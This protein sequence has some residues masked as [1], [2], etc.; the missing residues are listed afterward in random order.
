MLAR[1]SRGFVRRVARL[2]PVVLA[3]GLAAALPVIVSTIRAVKAGWLPLGDDAMIVVRALDV[4]STHSPLVGAHSASSS[5]I[6]APVASP[7][8]MLFWLLALPARLGHVAP[9]I[10]MGAV[11]TAAVVGMVALARRRGGVVLMLVVAGALALMCRSL[12]AQIYHDVWNPSAAVLPFAL[13]VFLAWSVA[14]GEHALLPLIVVVGSFAAQAQLAYALPV[15]ALFAVALAFLVGSRVPVPRRT[16][17]GA[18]LALLVCWSLPLAEEVVHR[19]GNLVRIGQVATSDVHKFGWGPGWHSVEHAVGVAPWWL[20]P[21]RDGLE[22]LADVGF[23]P[24][25]LMTAS[26]LALLAALVAALA[27]AL[28]RGERDLAAG[29]ALALALCAA[30]ATVTARSPT[31]HDL[32][33][34]IGYTLWWAAVAGMFAWVVLGWAAIRLLRPRWRLE[35]L[36]PALMVAGVAAVAAIGVAVSAAERPDPRHRNYRPVGRLLDRVRDAVPPGPAVRVEGPSPGQGLAAGPAVDV[37]AAIA[38]ELRRGGV[39]LVTDDV[40]GIGHRYD[41]GPHPYSRV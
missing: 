30:V 41:P 34:T 21:Q 40:I 39:E 11:N 18:L 23:A 29:L 1:V 16:I 7:G 6:G 36:R 5:V 14:A 25:A 4:L 20:R 26:A 9:A 2:D 19:P 31:E 37:V 33:S 13:L 27:L 22:R 3:T 15:L 17:V 35:A 32:F 28:R 10:A 38:Y 24:G 12:E 8:P